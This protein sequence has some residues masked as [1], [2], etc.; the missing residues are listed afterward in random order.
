M[1]SIGTSYLTH[2][3]VNK[4]FGGEGRVELENHWHWNMNAGLLLFSSKYRVEWNWR[5]TSSFQSYFSSM[6]SLIP[7][8]SQAAITSAKAVQLFFSF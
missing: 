3:K 7:W 5:I 6:T 2:L 1:R 4:P 8:R